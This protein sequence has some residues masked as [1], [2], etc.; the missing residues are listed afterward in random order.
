M[1]RGVRFVLVF[2][3]IV[4]RRVLAKE[5]GSTLQRVRETLGPSVP[6]IGCYTYGQLGPLGGR[7]PFGM[8]APQIGS[9]LVVAVG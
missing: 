5:P 8:C 2:D 6:V 1:L 7:A 3:S 9:C 4:R